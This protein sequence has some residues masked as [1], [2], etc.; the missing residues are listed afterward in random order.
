MVVNQDK[1]EIH[2]P[3]LSPDKLGHL[4]Q[5]FLL[6]MHKIKSEKMLLYLSDEQI[7]RFQEQNTDT[8]SEFGLHFL[9]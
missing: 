7:V 6:V 4:V 3:V 2:I 5:H 8:S 9:L 1:Y